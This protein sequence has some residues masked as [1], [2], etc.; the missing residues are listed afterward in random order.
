ML[1]IDERQRQLTVVHPRWLARWCGKKEVLIL[2]SPYL[3]YP[4][5][6]VTDSSIAGA[7]RASMCL[8]RS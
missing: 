5:Y 7:A 6:W 4:P 2:S 3:A 1:L 8:N